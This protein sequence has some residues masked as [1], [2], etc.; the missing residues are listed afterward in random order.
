MDLRLSIGVKM[1]I[2]KVNSEDF[3]KDQ[4]ID[5]FLSDYLEDYS[6]SKL[7][8]LIKEKKVLISNQTVKPSYIVKTGDIVEL[9]LQDLEIKELE[10]E[11]IY[12]D[13]IY[14]DSDIA[15]INKPIGMLS[16]PTATI[17]SNTLVNALLNRF[18]QLSDINGQDRLGVVHRLDFNTSGLMI[19][20][21][22]NEA[23]E[24]LKQDFQNRTIIKKYRAIVNG[25][26]DE[27]EGLLDFPIARNPFNRKLMAV[28]ESGKEARTGYKVLMEADGFSY[29]D[30]DL[31][32]GRTHQI[33]V[34]LSHIN[35]P[36]LG[37]KDYGGKRPNFSIDHQLLQSYYL[38][39]SHP[40]SGNTIELQLEES[41]EISKY[42]KIIFKEQ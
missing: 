23:A 30:L 29:L 11:D 42:R 14:E 27:K 7:A 6:R 10:A 17:R 5:S 26:F 1:M 33:R 21:L 19:V 39:F 24:I 35:K 32:T 31:F 9:D 16:H 18:D 8:K 2:I 28:V 4:R 36:I 25:V 15:V 41:S 38:K 34:H 3:D 13:V 37:D 20:A 12:L 22:T 40:I